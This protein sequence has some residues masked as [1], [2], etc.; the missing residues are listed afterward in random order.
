MSRNRKAW[1]HAHTSCTY[2]YVDNMYVR[3]QHHVKGTEALEEHNALVGGVNG[4]CFG[5]KQCCL[6]G[7]T[8][9]SV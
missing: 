2:L 3:T 1:M 5:R 8:H 9:L 6:F 4:W 7:A